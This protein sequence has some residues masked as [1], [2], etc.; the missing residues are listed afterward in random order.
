[1]HQPF[2]HLLLLFTT[3]LRRRGT[4]APLSNCLAPAETQGDPSS[5]LFTIPVPPPPPPP[6]FAAFGIHQCSVPPFVLLFFSCRCL[7]DPLIS[8]LLRHRKPTVEH[9]SPLLPSCQPDLPDPNY[10][11]WQAEA[12]QSTTFR[13]IPIFSDP[14]FTDP[15]RHQLVFPGFFPTF[16]PFASLPST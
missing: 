9:E 16:F 3:Q 5:S 12:D 1:V 10:S 2:R 13:A 14:F 6:H 11:S 4:S 7:Y 15:W 8:L